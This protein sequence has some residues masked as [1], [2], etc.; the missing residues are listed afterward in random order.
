M[1]DWLHIRYQFVYPTLLVAGI[2]WTLLMALRY[3]S[4]AEVEV[5]WAAAIGAALACMGGLGVLALWMSHERGGFD[6]LTSFVFTL[7]VAIPALVT[8][9]GAVRLF[10]LS[11]RNGGGRG[12]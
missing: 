6:Q 10:W 1:I 8:L 4:C 2:A 3:R 5:A 11:W 9:A 12:H 7:A